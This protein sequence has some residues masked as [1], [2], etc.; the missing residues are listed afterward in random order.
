[1][2]FVQANEEISI[3]LP[4]AVFVLRPAAEE[5]QLVAGAAGH[6]SP[7]SSGNLCIARHLE[8][9]QSQHLNGI[10][11]VSRWIGGTVAG[12]SSGQSSC[13]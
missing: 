8:G 2:Q 3:E 11:S 10:D 12:I 7:S 4:E 5:V 6:H 1:M 13:I 9:L